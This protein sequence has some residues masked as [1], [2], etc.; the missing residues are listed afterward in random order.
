MAFSRD[1]SW[2]VFIMLTVILASGQSQVASPGF[3][4]SIDKVAHFAVFGALA[5]SLIRLP[6]FFRA[7]RTG[8]VGAWVL[9]AGFGVLDEWR[10]S[11]T[12]GRSV[13]VADGLADALGA[14]VAIALYVGWRG[15]R[16]LLE[17]PIGQGVR[18]R[19]SKVH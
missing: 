16:R 1:S 7:G 8:V 4:F 6:F 19:Q 18:A 15:Y 10:Q 14:A 12:P 11:F 17:T 3:G 9:A 13:E 2:P 5:T